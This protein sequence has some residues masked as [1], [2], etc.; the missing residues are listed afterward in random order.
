MSTL[1]SASPT[2]HPVSK[3]PVPS[4]LQGSSHSCIFI[5]TFLNIL[6]LLLHLDVTDNFVGKFSQTSSP[7]KHHAFDGRGSR[8]HG[9]CLRCFKS[10]SVLLT[11]A[12]EKAETAIEDVTE[13]MLKEDIYVYITETEHITVLDIPS[14]SVSVESESAPG[15]R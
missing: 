8:M 9:E 11:G 6:Y 2:E 1:E 12:G 7:S 5:Y 15:V 4:H 13:D 14:T 3:Q 10:L